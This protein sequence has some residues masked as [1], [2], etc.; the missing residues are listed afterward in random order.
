MKNPSDNSALITVD[1]NMDDI[2]DGKLLY[3]S[4]FGRGSAKMRP[5]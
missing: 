1:I 4:V 3:K 5:G 2:K